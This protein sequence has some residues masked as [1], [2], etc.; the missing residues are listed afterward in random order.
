MTMQPDLDAS[1]LWPR[2]QSSLAARLAALAAFF[3]RSRAGCMLLL[4]LSI[5]PLAILKS[6]STRLI[7]DE[8]YT[9]RIAQQ[10]TIAQMLHLSRE[11]DLHP[12]LHYFLQRAALLTP[13]PVWLASRLPSIL[14]TT[15]TILFVFL[16]AARR[17]CNLL[18][19]FAAAVFFLTPAIEFS[20][21]NR[22]YALWLYLL[23]CTAVAYQ[24][25]TEPNR[26]RW[27]PIALFVASLAMLLSYMEGLVCLLP[28]FLAEAL[29]TYC[30]KHRDTPIWLALLLP[31]F[32]LILYLRPAAAF[33]NNSF[34]PSYLHPFDTVMDLYIATLLQPVLVLVAC[35][36]AATVLF[37]TRKGRSSEIPAL[38]FSRQGSPPDSDLLVPTCIVLLPLLLAIVALVRHTQFFP[39]YG[40]CASIGIALLAPS[41]LLRYVRHPRAVAAFMALAM[42]IAATVQSSTANFEIQG[43]WRSFELMGIQ[44]I[45]LDALSPSLPIVVANAIGYTEMNARESTALLTHTYYLYDRDN[46][47]R[48]SGSTVFENEYKIAALLGYRGQTAPLY[49]FLAIH[50]Q[51]YLIADYANPEE[52]LPRKLMALGVHPQYLGRFVSTYRDLDLYLVT[53]PSPQ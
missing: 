31:C 24:R 47:I 37:T 38:E 22:P 23:A 17:T 2:I 52:W 11:V 20:W 27:L 44:P 13:F 53:L 35:I 51:F 8:I 49:A 10:P 14:A 4:V 1:P 39:R 29:R 45:S 43:A 48:F 7:G 34:V 3:D 41:F 12:P 50:R 5:L 40:A 16:F 18:G 46:A 9:L 32:S 15:A 19:F 6:H 25:A 42:L 33:A 28:F 26:A 30:K 21:L 36:L